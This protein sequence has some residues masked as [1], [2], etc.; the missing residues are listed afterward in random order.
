MYFPAATAAVVPSPTA[1]V[2]C[3]TSCLRTSP[4]AQIALDRGFHVLIGDDVAQAVLADGIA[5]DIGVGNE[6]D[7]RENSADGNVANLVSLN[8]FNRHRFD[9]VFAVDTLNDGIPDKFDFLIF[10]GPLLDDLGRA[11]LIAAV[12]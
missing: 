4:M 10:K 6:T 12:N 1:L 5:E 7:E 3:L 9:F 8:I 2:T 11:K